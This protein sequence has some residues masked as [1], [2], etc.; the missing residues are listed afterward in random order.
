[1][2]YDITRYGAVAD[3]VAKC[4]AAIQAAIDDC[5][6]AGGGRVLFPAGVFLSGSLRLR[7][8]VE[9][10]LAHGAVLRSSLDQA[11]MIDFA[12]DFDDDN[13]D[14][15][16]EGGCFLFACHEKNIAVTGTGTID[17][18]GRLTFYDDG[19]DHGL[20]ECALNVR[21]FRPRMSFLEDVENLTV[22]GV[23]FYDA[24][25]W[26]L[27]MAG[28]RN[29]LI[30]NIRILNNERGPNNDGIDPDS[31]QNVVIRGCLIEGGDDSVVIKTTGPMTRRYGDC[32]NILVQNCIM[33]SRSS[34]IKIGTE[35]HGPIHHVTISDCLLRDCSR[36]IGIW[37][38]DGGEIH[39]I[40]IHHVSGNTR[41]FADCPERQGFINTW[42]GKG[43]PLFLSATKRAGVDRLPGK[44]SRIFVDHL[45]TVS[46]SGIL[47]AGESYAPIEN[48]RVADCDILY[49]QQSSHRPGLLDEQPSARGY[50]PHEIPCVYLRSVK[51]VTVEGRLEVDDSLRDCIRKRE[52]RE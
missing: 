20:G 3:G 34:A 49:K 1:M 39:D 40:S 46:E 14:T 23:T 50:Y 21:G 29:V 2:I 31:C 36:G 12:R 35:T 13:E 25:Y 44:I 42:W 51:D 16:W 8:N 15:G 5:A 48:V 17:G 45:Q 9:L 22:R 27:H 37:S 28:C 18:Q 11:D 19:A 4:T 6:A 41:R 33:H 38:R 43:E 47:I 24:A 26:T 52:I 32:A 30:D 7:S 10:H